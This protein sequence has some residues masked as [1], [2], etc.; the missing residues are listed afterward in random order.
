MPREPCRERLSSGPPRRDRIVDY[1]E[2]KPGDGAFDRGRKPASPARGHNLP[3]GIF[4]GINT[5]AREGRLVHR[6]RHQGAKVV[7]VRLREHIGVAHAKDPLRRIAAKDPGGQRNRSADRFEIARGHRDDQPPHLAGRD[8]PL[9]VLAGV[10][11]IGLQLRRPDVGDCQIVHDR[12]PWR[13]IPLGTDYAYANVGPRQHHRSTSKGVTGTRVLA[14]ELNIACEHAG[15]F[16][17]IR[18]DI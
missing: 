4:P 16:G 6:I 7:V 10:S 17:R 8:L 12:G 1:H 15:I 3:L 18:D 11:R 2:V 9:R 13:L 5:H 14:G